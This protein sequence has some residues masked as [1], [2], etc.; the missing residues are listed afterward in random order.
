MKIAETYSYRHAEAIL[1]SEYAREKKE[2]L[3]CL[4]AAKWVRTKPR[5]RTRNGRV[6]A[7][8]SINQAATNKALEAVFSKR[9]WDI[10]PRIISNAASQLAADFKKGKI[11]VEVQFGNM[12]RWYTDVFKF[13]LSYSADDI[14][15]GVLAIPMHRT[16]AIIDENVVNYERVVRELPHAK[17]GITIPIWVLGLSHK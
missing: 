4:R 3:A 9:G 7:R 16:A 6:V 11:Q 15:V 14:E 17:M 12:A 2:I 5:E 10:H 1:D 8:L 13:L